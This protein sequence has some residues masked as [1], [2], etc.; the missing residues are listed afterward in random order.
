M[1][2]VHR[3]RDDPDPTSVHPTSQGLAHARGRAPTQCVLQLGLQSPRDLSVLQEPEIGESRLPNQEQ[4]LEGEILTGDQ[5]QA[6]RRVVLAE[7]PQTLDSQGGIEAVLRAHIGRVHEDR[8]N[9]SVT[10]EPVQSGPGNRGRKVMGVC[11]L[12]L[13]ARP[14]GV[15]R[16]ANR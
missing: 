4:Q 11:D 7:F 15:I 5:H 16:R 3:T 8:R 6:H 14:E 2:E 13:Q 1:K 12:A 9:R 10:D